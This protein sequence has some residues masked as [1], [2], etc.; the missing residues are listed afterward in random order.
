MASPMAESLMKTQTNPA[1]VDQISRLR[2]LTGALNNPA[3]WAKG[4]ANAALMTALQRHPMYAKAKEL[5]DRY[6]GDWNK[7]FEETAKSN[8]IDP[9]QITAML[10]KQ[11]LV[12]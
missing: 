6:G 2:Q 12:R 11:G 10:R 5:A 1:I 4:A 7:A 3:G 9:N 8:G